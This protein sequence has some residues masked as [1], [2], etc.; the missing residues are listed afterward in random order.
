MRV[1]A[2]LKF[3]SLAMD[4]F[5]QLFLLLEVVPLEHRV[6]VILHVVQHRVLYVEATGCHRLPQLRESAL[7]R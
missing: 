5:H 7:A 1:R 6:Q 4:H 2:I 3:I